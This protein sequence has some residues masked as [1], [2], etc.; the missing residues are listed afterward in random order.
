MR[1]ELAAASVMQASFVIGKE[2]IFSCFLHVQ[3]LSTILVV[4]VHAGHLV[5]IYVAHQNRS[6]I[7]TRFF[8]PYLEILAI[9]IQSSRFCT[10]NASD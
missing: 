5:T 2:F 10:K 3:S 4:G 1:G 8:I 7:L 6:H 9:I